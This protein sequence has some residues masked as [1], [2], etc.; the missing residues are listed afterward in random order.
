MKI[1]LTLCCSTQWGQ[2]VF[3]C[4]SQNHAQPIELA[5]IAPGV[6]SAEISSLSR[7]YSY[8]I[9]ENEHVV[10]LEP[11]GRHSLPEISLA[12]DVAIVDF[13]NNTAVPS[14]L[15]TSA[16]SQSFFRQN[17]QTKPQIV[18]PNTTLFRV[19][20][21]FLSSSQEL[22]L[23][24]NDDT[25]GNWKGE[26]AA[27]FIPVAY[28]E[29]WL[30]LQTELLSEDTEYKLAIYDKSAKE[31]VRWEIGA[32]RRLATQIPRGVFILNLDAFDLQ[33]PF[34][35]SGVA[36]P[37]FSL[38]SEKNYGVGDF[39][40]LKKMVDWATL[41]GQKVI[42]ILPINDTTNNHTWRDSYPY[43]AISIYALHPV[44]LGLDEFPLKDE[45]KN[46]EYRRQGNLLNSL[47]CMDYE[48][49]ITL[50]TN[51]VNDLFLEIGERCLATEDYR[52]FVERNKEWLF[53]Y[54]CYSILRDLNKCSN[55]QKWPEFSIYNASELED[56]VENQPEIKNG[57]DKIYFAQ[58]LLDKQLSDVRD[59]AHS[60]G[61]ILKGDIPIGVNPFSVDAW[62]DPQLFNLDTQTGAPPDDFAV[63]GQNW[64][65]PT[66]NWE[67]MAKNGY[68]WWRKRFSKM[69]DY[70]DAYRIDHILGFF[71]IWEIPRSAVHALLGH[72]SPALPFSKEEIEAYGFHFD[73]ESMTCP[74]MLEEDAKSLFGE[75]LQKALGLFLHQ[76]GEFLY[77][78]DEF[79][80]QTQIEAYFSDKA[81]D[82]QQSLKEQLLLFGDE[83]LFIRDKRQPDRFHPR[84]SAYLS[85]RFS[86][87]DECRR[88][89]FG[90]LYE[91]F[92]YHRHNEFWKTESMKKLPELLHATGMLACGEDLGMIPAC[93]PEV[94]EELNILS[95]VIER[96]PK[97]PNVAFEPLSKIP[98]L[99]VCTTSTHDMSPIRLWW[100]EDQGLT[101]RYF[102]EVLWKQGNAPRECTVELCEQILVNHLASPAM[103]V[104]LPLQ[105]WMSI[106]EQ[107]RQRPAEEERINIPANS[108]HYWRYRM[109]W[110]LEDLLKNKGTNEYISS[111]VGKHRIT[112]NR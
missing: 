49:V 89:V 64:G 81:S 39:P 76:Q 38:R 8:Q 43:N 67:E 103:L 57:K 110:T 25:F 106:D 23:C 21:L 32:N 2:N 82:Q 11:V 66:Y 70:F 95:L 6:W 86:G 88:S 4:P 50:K 14:Y 63:L 37:V 5:C 74:S 85:K 62:T 20:S 92:Y 104:V 56:W 36:V 100:T 33:M 68:A 48:Q 52:K 98:S 94:M 45:A 102:N 61:V 27:R 97:S 31:I 9:W 75:N 90:R 69:A 109:H 72:F 10:L 16:F 28:G 44:Y 77:L 53:P 93:V 24:G 46:R 1:R 111:L 30:P 73:E 101:Q 96:M 83:V 19:E 59:Y 17:I 99:S 107:W 71:R 29:W 84:I 35:A 22:I 79:A 65:F 91:D 87:L 60:H 7:T 34:R 47:P 40:S 26:S 12:N 105:D 18:F 51:Y 108:N 55:F 3:V 15:K 41:T 78:E 80:T 42:Q 58:Y 13:W 54:A 112:T